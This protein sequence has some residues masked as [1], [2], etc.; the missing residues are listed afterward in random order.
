MDGECEKKTVL[1]FLKNSGREL[2]EKPDGNNI[3]E[4]LNA[5]L[6]SQQFQTYIVTKAF[7]TRVNDA[8]KIRASNRPRHQPGFS[9]HTFGIK[10]SLNKCKRNKQRKKIT[11]Y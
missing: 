5:T 1:Y 8:M 3:M 11:V 4:Y 2:K 9:L 6:H 7:T 10:T